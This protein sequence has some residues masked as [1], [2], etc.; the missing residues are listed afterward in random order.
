[1]KTDEEK[2]EQIMLELGFPENLLGTRYVRTAVEHYRPG[3]SITGELY[4]TVAAAYNTSPARVERAIRH[5]TT[6]AFD[7]AGWCAAPMRYFGNS[8]NPKTGIPMN[9]ELIARLERITRAD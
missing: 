6:R 8:I 4:P 5:A 1:M 2:L 3:M 7:R 9:S